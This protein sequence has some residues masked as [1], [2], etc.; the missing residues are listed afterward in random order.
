VSVFY[1]M[2]MHIQHG[3]KLGIHWWKCITPIHKLAKWSL[4]KS[5]II[6]IKTRWTLVTILQRWKTLQMLLHL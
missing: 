1:S 4:N 6:Y 3:S 2:I 5:C